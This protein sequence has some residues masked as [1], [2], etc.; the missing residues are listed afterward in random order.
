MKLMERAIKCV[1]EEYQAERTASKKPL[2]ESMTTIGR[3]D[4]VG[5]SG[6]VVRF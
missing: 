4:V 5:S 1:E 2:V 3:V 6:G